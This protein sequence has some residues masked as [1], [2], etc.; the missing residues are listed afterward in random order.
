MKAQSEW[1]LIK[2]DAIIDEK[3]F[4]KVEERRKARNP[5]N[6]YPRG[7]LVDEIRIVGKGVT[8]RGGY[9]AL[10]QVLGTKKLGNPEW[11][12]Q[13]WVWPVQHK[14]DVQPPANGTGRAAGTAPEE[15]ARSDRP[16]P[17]Q[18]SRWPSSLLPARQGLDRRR[19][20]AALPFWH[21]PSPA[22][23]P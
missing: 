17:F 22:S 4:R 13:F 1:I 8:I 9:S 5:D 10:G 21:L 16:P 7:L 23:R 15:I 19:I 2:V 18:M 14:S 6:V 20:P 3:T 12:S 11:G